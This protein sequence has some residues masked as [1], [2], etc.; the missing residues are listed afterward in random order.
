MPFEHFTHS[1]LSSAVIEGVDVAENW[2]ISI[3]ADHCYLHSFFSLLTLIGSQH[4]KSHRTSVSFCWTGVFVGLELWGKGMEIYYF[5]NL[6]SE[7]VESFGFK[8]ASFQPGTTWSPLSL[9]LKNSS[10]LRVSIEVILRL[11]VLSYFLRDRSPWWVQNSLRSSRLLCQLNLDTHIWSLGDCN[12]ISMSPLRQR[13]LIG[14]MDQYYSNYIQWKHSIVTSPIQIYHWIYIFF[15]R[16]IYIHVY[17]ELVFIHT[18]SQNWN[19]QSSR[20]LM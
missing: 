9:G 17:I 15:E 1:S 4:W 10:L 16:Y 7:P 13:N 20:T 3:A 18:Y 14:S 11:F 5:E 2:E 6:H 19:C 12:V 8:L